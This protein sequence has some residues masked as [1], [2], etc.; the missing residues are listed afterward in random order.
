MKGYIYI[1][2]LIIIPTLPCQVL[3][4]E[5]K[6]SLNQQLRLAYRNCR[7]EVIK[8]RNESAETAYQQG[9]TNGFMKG[10]KSGQDEMLASAGTPPGGGTMYNK[11][12]ENMCQKKF[13]NKYQ[14]PE[15]NN[16]TLAK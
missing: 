1:F 3:A 15:L 5:N 11:R 6:Q 2:C 14:K 10:F 16:R 12:I 4:H 8:E 13:M 7:L 9:F